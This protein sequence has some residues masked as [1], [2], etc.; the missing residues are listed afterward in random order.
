MK[1]ASFK[2][3]VFLILI[4]VVCPK[5]LADTHYVSKMSTGPVS[6]YT[7]WT[8]ATPM[9]QNAVDVADAGDTILVANGV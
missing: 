7:N 3:I 8:T 1:T 4:F 5:I 9:I 6:P 2:F